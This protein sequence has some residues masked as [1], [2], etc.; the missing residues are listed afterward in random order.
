MH[1]RAEQCS[2]RNAPAV[3]EVVARLQRRYGPEAVRWGSDASPAEAW[4]TGIPLLDGI[5][6]AS[7]LPCGRLSAPA[8]EG[9]R[10][11]VLAHCR[12]RA[13]GWDMAHGDVAGLRV[14]LTGVALAGAVVATIALGG[15]SSVG[16]AGDHPPT[17]PA[18]SNFA[19][20]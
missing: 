13:G 20:S 7:G 8:A 17:L 11:R 4:A 5:T 15:A 6:P 18:P 9:A 12:L 3:H 2:L 16:G 19:N 1:Q 10:L 14:R